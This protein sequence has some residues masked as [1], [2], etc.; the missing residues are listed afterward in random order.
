VGSAKN[1]TET[2]PRSRLWLWVLAALAMQVAV[3]TAWLVFAA[4]HEVAEVPL[5]TSR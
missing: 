3:W 4:H 2:A 1:T 5:A